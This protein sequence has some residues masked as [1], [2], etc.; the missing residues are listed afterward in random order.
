MAAVT[1]SDSTNNKTPDNTGVKTD[2]KQAAEPDKGKAKEGTT[3]EKTDGVEAK[4]EGE[5]SGDK[6]KKKIAS[7]DTKQ[8]KK[9]ATSKSSPINLVGITSRIFSEITTT[10]RYVVRRQVEGITDAPP[11]AFAV[12]HRKWQAGQFMMY[13][14]HD[15][16]HPSVLMLMG[17]ERGFIVCF[18][19]TKTWMRFVSMQHETLS[20]FVE[21]YAPR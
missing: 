17:T 20:S 13:M 2:K 9:V 5:Y 7:T 21:T 12:N 18:E 4:I 16:N 6:S 1:P 15:G 10:P 14:T 3:V 11:E 19:L 8:S